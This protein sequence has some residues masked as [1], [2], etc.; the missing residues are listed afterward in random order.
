MIADIG[1]TWT[2][3]LDG[4]YYHILLT[5]DIIKEKW[6]FRKATGHLGKNFSKIYINELEAL[7]R[8]SR[9]LIKENNFIVVDVGSRDIKYVEFK[10]GFFSKLDW[11]QSCG[12]TTGFTLELIMNYYGL[13][14]EDI[15]VTESKP[16]PI[17]CSVFGLEKVFDSIINNISPEV[18]IG[19]FI[20]SL[21]YN[22][23]EFSG[24]PEKIYLSGG[25][26]ENVAFVKALSMLCEV[27]LLGRFVLLEG[28]K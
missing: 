28:I 8:G 1:T 5:K 12:A 21:V 15:I 2:K 17:T 4:K 20:K 11:N 14:S 7:A 18:A 26:C 19:D 16:S 3:I 23:Y 10:N 25:M 27:F 13:K 9:K 22:I 24:K 6:Y